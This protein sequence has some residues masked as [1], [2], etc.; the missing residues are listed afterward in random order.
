MAHGIAAGGT[1]Q[2]GHRTVDMSGAM[3]YSEKNWG[4]SFPK[5]WWWVQANTFP[6]HPDLTITAVGA[7]RAIAGLYEE[8]IGMIAV[9]LDGAMYEFSNWSARSLSWAVA[10][11]G[12]WEARATARTGHVVEVVAETMD[13]GAK[14]LGPSVGGMV[15]NVRD[16][17]YGALVLSLTAPD[18]RELLSRATCTSAQVEVGGGPWDAGWECEVQPLRQPLRGIINL[19][20]GRKVETSL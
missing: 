6:A 15:Y 14:V 16:A 5:Q 1:L 18:G 17:A 10:P 13:K 4:G 3:L 11:W 2:Y 9:H 8:E 12:L 7:R 20:A 19:G